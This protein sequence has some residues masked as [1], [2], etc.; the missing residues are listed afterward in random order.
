VGV[1][2]ELPLTCVAGQGEWSDVGKS[3]SESECLPNNEVPGLVHGDREEEGGPNPE[4][5]QGHPCCCPEVPVE[6]VGGNSQYSE[7]AGRYSQSEEGDGQR[8]GEQPG[9]EPQPPQH[10]VNLCCPGPFDTLLLMFPRVGEVGKV[11]AATPG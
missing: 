7:V 5:E 10:V 9:Q 11:T 3:G 8:Q 6:F 2:P 4:T 1:P